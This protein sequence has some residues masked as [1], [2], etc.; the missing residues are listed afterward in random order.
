VEEDLLDYLLYAVVVGEGFVNLLA[1]LV[2]ILHA[3]HGPPRPTWAPIVAVFV[4]SALAL[5]LTAGV[6]DVRQWSRNRSG[7]RSL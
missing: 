6:A 1:A 4:A 3:L 2:L 5:L 7:R